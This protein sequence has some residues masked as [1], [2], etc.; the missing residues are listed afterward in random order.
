MRILTGHTHHINSVDYN[1]KGNLIVSGSADENVRI[2]DVKQSKC[3]RILAAHSDPVTAVHFS[4]DG[5]IIVSASHDGLIRL[6]DTR[7]GQCLKTLVGQTKSP[8]THVRF[9]PNGLYILSSTMDGC[10]RL[11]EYMRDKC[12]K[13]YLLQSQST[14]TTDDQP[15]EF[16][17][18]SASVFLVNQEPPLICQGMSQ[19]SIGIWDV[20]TKAMV[21]ELFG[22]DAEVLCVDAF[23]NRLASA[24][25]DC[26]VRLWDRI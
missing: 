13:T 11:W 18:S 2:W 19:N 16:K 1:F 9:S 7:T 10:I 21:D 3:L 14:N 8:V 22:H 23:E 4:P 17:Y 20:Q 6:W 15:L 26:T 12:V 25:M 5:T 24:S